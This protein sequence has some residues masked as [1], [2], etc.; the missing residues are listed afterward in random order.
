MILEMEGFFEETESL[1]PECLGRI[2]ARRLVEGGDVYLE[3]ACP[4]HGNF[5]VLIWRGDKLYREWGI[6][7]VNSRLIKKRITSTVRGCPYDCGLCPNHEGETCTALMEVTSRCDI[8]CP[9]CFA[10]ANKDLGHDPNLNEIREMYQTILEASGPCP[11]QL[12]GGEPSIRD[13]LPDIIALGKEMGFGHIQINTHGLRIAKD[14][15]YLRRLKE[16][17]AD[18]IYLQFDGVSNDVYRH[19]RGANLFELKVQ[20]IEHCAEVKIGAIL[21]PTLIPRVN[22]HQIGDI[23]RFAKRQ[24]P[25]VK[26]IH[27]QPIS[28]FGRYPRAPRNEDRITIPD[29]LKALEVQTTREVKVKDFVPRRR[30]DSHCGFSAFYVLMEDGRLQ[31]TTNFERGQSPLAGSGFVKE[32]PA[33]HVRR[34]IYERA[35]FVEGETQE[36]QVKRGSWES[37]FNRARTHYLSISGMPFQDVWTVDLERLQGCCIHVVT[38]HEQLIPFCAFYLTSA[39]GER[40][41]YEAKVSS[42]VAYVS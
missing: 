28:Y 17:G 36:G 3:K 27:F 1:C 26:G 11:V 37:F 31:A 38:R 29:V 30:K 8:E 12:S 23:V 14:K 21:V 13:D 24:I 33:E 42:Q 18:L 35:R 9:V 7:E 20:A 15:E 39:S 10:S 25:V 34:F 32:S 4:D 5:K 22:D 41:H 19:T 2:P 16:A 40:L 6:G